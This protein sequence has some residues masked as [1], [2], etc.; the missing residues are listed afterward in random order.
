ML[1]RLQAAPP[2]IKPLPAILTEYVAF[3]DQAARR[4]ALAARDPALR[5]IVGLLDRLAD[6]ASPHSIL[7]PARQQAQ[8]AAKRRQSAGFRAAATSGTSAAGTRAARHSGAAF[9]AAD[10]LLQDAAAGSQASLNGCGL[11]VPSSTA[12]DLAP[13]AAV[14]EHTSM[15]PVDMPV[16][17]TGHQPHSARKRAPTRRKR[18]PDQEPSL[19]QTLQVWTV[20][21]QLVAA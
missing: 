1:Q 9:T 7:P 20:T 5:D 4:E 13:A 3:T 6:A 8:P 19:L 12:I 10:Q 11:M 2:G 15:V 18:P 16:V 17:A 14:L 21:P